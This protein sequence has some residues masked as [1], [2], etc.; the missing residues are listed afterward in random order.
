MP[1]NW[2]DKPWDM[3]VAEVEVLGLDDL[4]TEAWT[5][6]ELE[7]FETE[8]LREIVVGDLRTALE[9]LEATAHGSGD[10]NPLALQQVRGWCA[11]KRDGHGGRRPDQLGE[12]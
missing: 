8:E 11:Q 7:A 4:G 3:I 5:W 10:T 2:S 9:Q 12:S 1:A 6:F